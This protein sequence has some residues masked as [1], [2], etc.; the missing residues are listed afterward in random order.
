LQQHSFSI[1]ARTI[2]RQEAARV[3]DE[4]L[5]GFLHSLRA[6][7]VG[8]DELREVDAALVRFKPAG[9]INGGL[10]ALRAW[11]NFAEVRMSDW[12]IEAVILQPAAKITDR[13]RLWRREPGGRVRGV[14]ALARCG[15]GFGLRYLRRG[16]GTIFFHETLPFWI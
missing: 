6:G 11:G 13:L 14:R 7:A 1:A 5:A 2:N 4:L 3:G 10:V 16:L 12:H 9:S 8:G 15:G